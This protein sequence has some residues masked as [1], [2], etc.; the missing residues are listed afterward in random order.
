MKIKRAKPGSKLNLRSKNIN[1]EQILKIFS[2]HLFVFSFLVGMAFSM[3]C[4]AEVTVHVDAALDRIPISP[5][6]Y[7][8]NH[9]ISDDPK[10]PTADSVISL[11]HDLGIKILRL[12]GGN[13]QTKYNWRAKLTSHPDWFNNIYAHDWDFSAQEVQ[14]K[15]P[16][17]CALFSF[18]LI[19][20]VASSTTA[21]FGDWVWSQS[22]GSYPPTEWNLAGGGTF[23]FANG[24]YTKGADGTPA[25]YLKDWPA[26]SSTG[27]IDKWFKPGGLGLDTARFRFWNMD[28]EPEIW[29]STHDDIIKDTGESQ[30]EDYFAKYV[31]VAKSARAKW[32]GIQLVGP[33]TCNEWQ[34]WTFNG[35]RWQIG[36][37]DVSAME[38]FINRIGI[39]EQ[40]SGVRLLD[41][42]DIHFYPGYNDAGK[43]RN[44]LDVHRVYFDTIYN[45]PGSNG[46]HTIDKKW[47]QAVPN[48]VFLRIKRWMEQYLGAG[49]GRLACTEYGAADGNGDA[50]VH[51][52]SLASTLG[53]WAD[54]GFE[55]FTPWDWYSG[56]N[57]TMHLFTS[58]AKSIRVK[59]VSSL[60]SLVSAY[61]SVNAAGDS[62]TVIL[63]NRDQNG[64]QT[65]AVSFSNFSTGAVSAQTK[66]LAN[67]NGETFVS[68]TKNALSTGAVPI[69]AN[70]FS[71]SLPR[72]SVTAVLVSRSS[73]TIVT[74][75]VATL[76]PCVTIFTDSRY[77]HLLL[78]GAKSTY[79]AQLQ[80][81][82]GRTVISWNAGAASLH[83]RVSLRNIAGGAYIVQVEDFVRRQISIVK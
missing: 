72:L 60:D 50:N 43:V 26:D 20:K 18:Q 11:Y 78:R 70:S 82:N 83:S 51:A 63:V 16:G 41:V 77:L 44:L 3:A 46:I 67:L 69:V 32:P 23:T 7:G 61:S 36:N 35:H 58:T 27:I 45:W 79:R 9:G 53:T 42:Y 57:E 39:E 37:R 30:F 22:H 59:S 15:L 29:N 5:Y 75:P 76:K 17:V 19:G 21:N 66:R 40:A 52:V 33:V 14:N 28:N 6:I 81:I 38:Y 12:S 31:A 56:W 71:V 2:V 65:A 1:E 80:D 8:K 64:A 4:L 62:L 68:A 73:A 74:P 55:I 49:R 34:W 54:N 13:N 24:T 47:G 10:K 48:Y 25:L